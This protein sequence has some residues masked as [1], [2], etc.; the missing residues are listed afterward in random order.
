MV[1][2]ANYSNKEKQ[3]YLNKCV[4]VHTSHLTYTAFKSKQYLDV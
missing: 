2:P 4:V 1:P 3:T